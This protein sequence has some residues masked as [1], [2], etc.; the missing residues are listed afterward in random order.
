MQVSDVMSTRVI[1]VTPETGIQEVA[2]AMRDGEVGSVPVANEDRLVGMVTDRDI[3]IRGIANA[4]DLSTLTAGD[5][6]TPAVAYCF[7]DESLDDV[8]MSMAAQQVRRLPVVGRDKRLKGIVSLGDVARSAPPAASGVAL[9]K[10]S[11]PDTH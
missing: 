3:V 11:E 4:D 8:L 1:R 2:R 7:E 9:E 6:M 10:I 5:V